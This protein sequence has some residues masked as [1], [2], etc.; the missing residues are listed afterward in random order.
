[1]TTIDDINESGWGVYWATQFDDGWS[2][3]LRPFKHTLQLIGR[4]RGPT[5][6]DA[7]FEAWSNRSADDEPQSYTIEKRASL[8]SVRAALGLRKPAPADGERM[9]RA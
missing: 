7:V 6:E 1:M 4:G 3:I 9:R 8:D 5:L 2:V